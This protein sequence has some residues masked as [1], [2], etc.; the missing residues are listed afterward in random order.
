MTNTDFVIAV[1]TLVGSLWLLF[2]G[3]PM[4]VRAQRRRR[5]RAARIVAGL[6]ELRGHGE[7]IDDSFQLLLRETLIA[8]AEGAGSARDAA[9]LSGDWRRALDRLA[10][11]TNNPHQPMA[12]HEPEEVR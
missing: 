8:A 11:E 6:A 5:A 7:W 9:N 10:A 2:A 1:A 4:A 3:I 12:S